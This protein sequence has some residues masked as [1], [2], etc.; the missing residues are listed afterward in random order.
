MNNKI[1]YPHSISPVAHHQQLPDLPNSAA[2]RWADHVVNGFFRHGI[3]LLLLVL[4]LFVFLPFL[5]PLFMML[6][7]SDPAMLIYQLYAPFCHQLPQ[8]SWFLFG[9]KLTY[10]LEEIRQVYP[11]TDAWQLRAFIGTPEMGWKVAWSDRMI[12]FYTMTPV[13]GLFYTLPRLRLLKPISFHLLLLTLLPLFVDGTTHALND[14]SSGVSGSGFRDSNAWL[15]FLT[16]GAFPGFYAGD[17]LGTFNWWLRLLTGLVAAWGIAAFLF[18]WL[19]QLFQEE[20]MHQRM[21]LR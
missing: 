16:Y 11:Y 21:S 7:W 14:I 17:A 1:E 10:T 20:A 19:N 6:G 8:R 15:A 2:N 9:E 18:P 13:F 3:T 12:S 4:L 5:A